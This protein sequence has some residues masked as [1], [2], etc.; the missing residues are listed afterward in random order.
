MWST[1]F[2]DEDLMIDQKTFP[3]DDLSTVEYNLKMRWTF[4]KDIDILKSGQKG[5]CFKTLAQYPAQLMYFAPLK[6]SSVEAIEEL[7][8]A[9]GNFESEITQI[10]NLEYY[11]GQCN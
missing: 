4:E 7:L 10:Q 9:P 1:S 11:T 5:A 2:G 6:P 8:H 3:L